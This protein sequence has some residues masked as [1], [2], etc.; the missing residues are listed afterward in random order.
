MLVR[1]SASIST[2]PWNRNAYCLIY[3]FEPITSD[4]K[5]YVN[6]VSDKHEFLKHTVYNCEQA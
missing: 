2:F 4:C 3:D 5:F 6:N 1:L